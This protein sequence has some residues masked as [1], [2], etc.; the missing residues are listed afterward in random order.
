MAAVSYQAT[1]QDFPRWY[2]DDGQEVE[3]RLK[4]GPIDTYEQVTSLI[5]DGR[6]HKGVDFKAPVGT[7]VKAPFD[8][9][10]VKKNW[11]ARANGNCLW[12]EGPKGITTKMLHLERI[13]PSVKVGGR[14]KKGQVIATSGNT[15][16]STAPHLHYQLENGK[17]LVDP[18]KFHGTYRT[19]LPADEAEKARAALARLA[20][21]RMGR[22]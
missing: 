19:G 6:R 4:E 8:G 10:V 7:P 16:R 13:D 15:G 21:L 1:G 14:V 11:G 9:V 3:L 12:I 18:F 22:Q 5:N 20:T 2:T 17:R